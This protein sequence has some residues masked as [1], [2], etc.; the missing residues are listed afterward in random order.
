MWRRQERKDRLGVYVIADEVAKD[1]IE[2]ALNGQRARGP[3]L[4]E[5]ADKAGLLSSLF[6]WCS[7]RS[8]HFSLPAVRLQKGDTFRP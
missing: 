7:S 6:C 5:F 8:W 3:D 1:S 4:L 2:P